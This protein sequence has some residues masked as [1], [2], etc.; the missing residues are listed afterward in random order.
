MKV[1]TWEK[2]T[3]LRVGMYPAK[4]DDI[5]L[6]T[7]LNILLEQNFGL[8][9]PYEYLSKFCYMQIWLGTP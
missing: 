6:F 9:W 1:Y 7:Q 2:T 8:K 4:G 3:V 5:L